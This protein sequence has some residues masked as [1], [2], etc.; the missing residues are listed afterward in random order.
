MGRDRLKY[1]LLHDATIGNIC[2]K[3]YN[4]IVI[5]TMMLLRIRLLHETFKGLISLQKCNNVDGQRIPAAILKDYYICVKKEFILLV[6][7][8]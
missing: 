1:M 3:R 6:K 2:Y 4:Q 7:K 8:A 5:Y